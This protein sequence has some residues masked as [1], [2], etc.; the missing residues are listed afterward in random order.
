MHSKKIEIKKT[1]T[2][3]TTKFSFMRRKG[4][5]LK[6]SKKTDEGKAHKDNEPGLVS[7]SA[8]MNML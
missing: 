5:T 7:N 3:N 2:R 4:D 8:R 1:E 6:M